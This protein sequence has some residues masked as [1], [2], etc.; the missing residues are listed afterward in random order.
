MPSGYKDIGGSKSGDPNILKLEAATKVRPLD[1]VV[2]GW[3]QHS[4]EH[5]SDTEQF[6]A[7][8]CPGAR[9]C[10]LD[11][12]PVDA[13]GKNRFPISRRYGAN[14]WDYGTSSVK[15]L[16]GGPQI[17][18]K[19]K[20]A[21]TVGI[22]PAS[23]D[24][25]ILKSGQGIGTKYEVI[26]HDS[27]PFTAQMIEPGMLHS[28]DKYEQVA[29]TEEIFG[30][31]ERFGIDYDALEIPSYTLDEALAFKMP[32]TKF[33]G[34]TVEAVLDKEP[35]FAQWLHGQKLEQGQ[36]G[37]P[38]FLALQVAME[39]QGIVPA[40]EDAL[41]MMPEHEQAPVEHQVTVTQASPQVAATV[42]DM[43]AGNV[44]L[45]GPDGAEVEVPAVAVD[46][47]LA[48][49]Y[50]TPSE[51]EPVP[52]AQTIK[53]RINGNE[54]EF[55]AEQAAPLLASGA[56]ELVTDTPV[57]AEPEPPKVP[58]PDEI[59]QV[60][61][62]GV[63]VAVPM[64]YV[65]AGTLVDA[66]SATFEDPLV[67]A[68]HVRSTAAEQVAQATSP[69]TTA[70]S[71]SASTAD[72]AVDPEKPFKCD[73]CDQPGYKTQGALTAHK[74]REHKAA[75]PQPSA[76]PATGAAATLRDEVKELIAH[77]D[78]A[79]DYNRLLE[80]FRETVGKENFTEMD[81]AD[82]TKLKAKMIELTVK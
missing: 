48:A 52:A 15:V 14:V 38:V 7:V 64:A 82:L 32:Y 69:S 20:E 34:E 57:A 28:V 46:A 35:N 23:C 78:F 65:T 12:K 9:S 50:K 30:I 18:D 25:T 3:R 63:P 37:D 16:I 6:A 77:A 29:T 41:A 10:P 55:T 13:S 60:N 59:V 70:T 56:A 39:E 53:V 49:G 43:T 54:F 2:A 75:T 17:F 79:R 58:L 1:N 21:A 47:M 44:T 45:V 42:T 74:N 76:V 11:R 8:V 31:L 4:I 33:K 51:P 66:G 61:L 26:R 19:F 67:A 68:A 5:P 62:N 27:A 72:A 40:L 73:L 71:E 22:D 24:W 81:D 80:I 36:L